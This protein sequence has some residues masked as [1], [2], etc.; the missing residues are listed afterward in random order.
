MHGVP[1]M[2]ISTP[3]GSSLPEPYLELS[4]RFLLRPIRTGEDLDQANAVVKSLVVR[5][6]ELTPVER[7]YLDVLSDL[8]E[9]YETSIYPEPAIEPHVMLRELISFR[10]CTHPDVARETGIAE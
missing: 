10:G 9:R 8:V 3:P 7:D 4:R 6:G 2:A 5:M 1:A